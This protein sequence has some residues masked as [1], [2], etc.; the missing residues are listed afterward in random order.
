MRG[1][2]RCADGRALR[3]IFPLRP[4]TFP[5]KRAGVRE[6]D[7]HMNASRLKTLLAL[8][9]LLAVEAAAAASPM[10]LLITPTR[11]AQ[12]ADASLAAVTV[13][14]RAQIER[15]QP[16]S[17]QDLLTGVPGVSFSNSGGIGQV[18]TLSLRGT[19][20][21]H[22]LVLVDG[23]KVGSATTG[24]TAFQDLPVEQI[25][26]IEIVRGPRSSLYGSEAIGGVVQIFTRKGSGPARPSVALGVGS[27]GG[28]QAAA[29]VSGGSDT[30]WFNLNGSGFG[31]SG[32]NACYSSQGCFTVEP[33]KDGYHNES[34]AL[35][36]G[37]R[38]ANGVELD[39]HWLQAIGE[40]E[41][42]GFYNRSEVVEQVVGGSLRYAPVEPWLT[43]LR[44][45]RSRD[46]SDNY[47]GQT[48]QTRFDTL[49]DTASW[50]NDLTLYP[51]Q[52]LTLG[53]D[54]QQDQVDST[55][56]Y[57]QTSRRNTGVFGQYQGQWDAHDLQLSLRRDD[58]E[59]YGHHDT[60]TAAWGYGFANGVRLFASHGTAFKAA[61]FNDLYFPGFSNPDLK[62]E[63]SAS[64]E[65]GLGG[66]P[67][68]GAWSLNL[69]DTQIDELILFDF[70]LSKPVNIEE[71][72]IRGIEATLGGELADWEL[73]S[74]L[75]LQ[76]SENR[77]PGANDGNILPRRARQMVRLDAD[78]ALGAYRFGVTLNGAGQRYDNASNS[79]EM[80]GYGTVDLRAE[81][82]FAKA[83][84]LQGRIANL[85]A[86]D[87]ET[88]KFYNQPGQTWFL[89]LRYQP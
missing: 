30:S 74:T 77:T 55:T 69:F 5:K 70:S 71:A 38:F 27:R 36:A 18:T 11:T 21:D 53:V 78:R 86:H 64:S 8:S 31:S 50:Q 37:H 1:S 80:G 75:T 14:D 22:V 67:G 23:V 68:W 73:N 47:S 42:D 81:W 61:N 4:S 28:Y 58:N 60:A 48:F 25:E 13:I 10:S 34:A 51:G 76:Q 49:R 16:R 15:L 33:D 17:L 62:P 24:M 87:Y 41:Y 43:T 79:R 89:T 7:L 12:T 32:F 83:W 66:H 72:R 52:L 44:V 3:P 9:S 84:R 20:P 39:G 65:I 35:R 6:G 88:A 26:R 59:Q 45:G 40:N 57:D 19:E 85:L 54:W 2:G 56:L 63:E 46:E 82:L 29:G